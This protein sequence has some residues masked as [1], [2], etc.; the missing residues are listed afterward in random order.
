[1]CTQH[2]H[3]Y[4]W[5]ILNT[6]LSQKWH[7]QQTFDK[8]SRRADKAPSLLMSS[9]AIGNPDNGRIDSKSWRSPPKQTQQTDSKSWQSPTRRKTT[10]KTNATLIPVARILRE[11]FVRFSVPTMV[12]EIPLFPLCYFLQVATW[13]M[14]VQAYVMG[15][16][17]SS[18]TRYVRLLFE[19]GYYSMCSYYSNKYTSSHQSTLRPPE[20]HTAYTRTKIHVTVANRH[21]NWVLRLYLIST[22]CLC[23][24]SCEA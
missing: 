5:T 17:I 12:H 7:G 24:C 19:G 4:M 8:D 9:T 18:P 23:I 10:E 6:E 2:L 22:R 1:M 21:F 14:L 15:T 16:R 11:F 13:F 3:P 20:V